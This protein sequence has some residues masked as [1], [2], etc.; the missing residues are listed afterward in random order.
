MTGISLQISPGVSL[1]GWKTK[2]NT[3]KT[4]LNIPSSFRGAVRRGADILDWAASHFGAAL[5]ARTIA[6]CAALGIAA[7]TLAAPQTVQAAFGYTASDGGYIV[8]DGA[9]LV[10]T[11]T[12]GGDIS[13]CKY[14]GTELNDT[15]K[16]SCIASGLGASSVTAATVDGYIVITCVSTSIASSALT[17]YY[18]FE[19]G[20]DDIFMAD[21]VTSEPSVGE[22]RYIFRGQFNLLPNGPPDSDNNGNTGAIESTD[23]FGYANGWTTSKYYGSERAKDLTVKGATGTGVGVFVAFGNRE[24][25]MGGPFVRDIENQGDGTGS[26]QEIYNYMNSGHHLNVTIAGQTEAFRLNVLYGPYAYCFTNG[27]TPS[28]PDFSFIA[29]LNLTGYVGTAGRGRVVLNGLSGMNTAY[30]YYMGFS[31]STAQYWETLNSSGGGECYNMKPGTYNMVIYKNEL[32]VW[33]GSVSVTAGNGT[34]VH[35]ITVTDPSAVATIWRIGDWD[36]TPLEFLNGQTFMIRHPSDSRNSSWG[37]VSFGTGGANNKFPADQF[38]GDNSPTTIT[39]PLTAAQAGAAHTFNI[40]ITDAYNNGRPSVTINGHA[41]SNPGASN[42]PSDRC[43][44]VGTYRGN[45]TTFSWSIPAADFVTG[46]N[47]LTITPI[48][49]SSDLSAWLSASWAYDCVELDD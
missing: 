14:A 49:G 24:S 42:Q 23:V 34:T 47:T 25:S 3:M 19:N 8:N 33:T 11:I 1:A 15:T 28:V 32:A 18:I 45:N 44:T 7:I 2:N 16:A 17:H 13:S 37:P 35:T 38:R 36:G 4:T 6:A 29:N 5:V 30:T 21:Y 9:N 43:E 10:V 41:L 31:N 20:V 39:F 22:L 27:S 26:D 48:S 12:S 46:T 40:G